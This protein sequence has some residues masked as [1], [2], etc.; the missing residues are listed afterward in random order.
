MST[1]AVR[2]FRQKAQ[3]DAELKKKLATIQ[4]KGH[5]AVAASVK[6]AGEAGFIFTAQEYDDALKEEIARQHA[7]AEMSEEQL[8]RV[9]GGNDLTQIHGVRNC[10]PGTV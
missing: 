2:A 3:Q 6:L 7:A 5:T 4:A 9:A 8:G 1:A 10:P